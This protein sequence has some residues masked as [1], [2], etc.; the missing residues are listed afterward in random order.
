[1]WHWAHQSKVACDAWW[2]KETEWHRRWKDRFPTDWQEVIH[3]DSVSG[4]KHIAD[5]KTP[6]GLTLEFQY[7]PIHPAEVQ[8]REA[9]YGNM[10]WIV[11][12]CRNELDPDHFRLSLS[13]PIEAESNEFPVQW[14]SR[15]RLFSNW[16][17]SKKPV[18]FDFGQ[19]EH[20]WRLSHFDPS[21]MKGAVVW[22]SREALV[23][24]WAE[25]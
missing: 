2:E 16:S 10:I 18:F 23:S 13:R 1:V 11:D 25:T 22:Y 21:T 24:L 6:S 8:A 3:H 9:F 4:E 12:G 5:V 7:S 19:P 17:L 14:W 20:L 15:S